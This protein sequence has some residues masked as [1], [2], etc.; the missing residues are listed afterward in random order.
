MRQWVGS[1]AGV[2]AMALA[3]GLVT[4]QPGAAGSAGSGCAATRPAELAAAVAATNAER[5]SHGLAALR[6]DPRLAE[7]AARHAC[8]MARRGQMTHRS[9]GAAGPGARLKALGYRPVVT[10]E[11]IAAGPFDLA[12]VLAA[13]TGSAG[14]RAN[15]LIPQARDF[16]IGSALGADGRTIFWSAVYAA[17]R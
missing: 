5:A 4:V 15:L 7:A 16:G 12:Q 2:L 17:P 8:D 1:G 10:A 9:A 3:M 14:H 13:W 6:A 11:N